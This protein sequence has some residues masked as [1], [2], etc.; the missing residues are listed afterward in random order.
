MVGAIW[1][2]STGAPMVRPFCR[3]GSHDEDGHVAV[4]RVVP[5]VL[6][7]LG[8]AA[9]VDDAVLGDAGDVGVP[10]IADRD[11]EEGRGGSAGVDLRQPGRRDRDRVAR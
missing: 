8:L 4:L 7:D 5:A 10:G 2:V 1:V 9:G 3:P 6:G 11:A